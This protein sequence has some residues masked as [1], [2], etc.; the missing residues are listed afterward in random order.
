M[1]EPEALSTLASAFDGAKWFGARIYAGM[2]DGLAPHGDPSRWMWD[3]TW[4]TLSY[5]LSG[6]RVAS[7]RTPEMGEAA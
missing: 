5:A 7:R 1:T 2:Q 3:R 6:Y 4:L